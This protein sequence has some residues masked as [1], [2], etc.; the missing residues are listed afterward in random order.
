MLRD[1][2][3][4]TGQE[5]GI[6]SLRGIG[7]QAVHPTPGKCASLAGREIRASESSGKGRAPQSHA[8]AHGRQESWSE[9]LSGATAQWLAE[10]ATVLLDIA[11]LGYP[12]V[13]AA[14]KHQQLTRPPQSIGGLAQTTVPRG[15]FDKIFSRPRDTAVAGMPNAINPNRCRSLSR[16]APHSP[17]A[18]RPTSPAPPRR[19]GWRQGLLS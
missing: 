11:F 5:S 9:R 17:V 2:V 14:R 8:Q 18:D 13:P 15:A 1:S 3:P 4:P 10:N 16:Y 6:A 7:G 19:P 12:P